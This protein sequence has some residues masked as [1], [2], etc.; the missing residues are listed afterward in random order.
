MS[1]PPEVVYGKYT[2]VHLAAEFKI[3]V[4]NVVY[5]IRVLFV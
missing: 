3:K 1:I 4:T 2:A 5:E